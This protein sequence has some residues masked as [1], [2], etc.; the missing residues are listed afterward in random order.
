MALILSFATVSLTVYF[1]CLQ[2]AW[3]QDKFVSH[4]DAFVSNLPTGEETRVKSNSFKWNNST[5]V[6]VYCAFIGFACLPVALVDW[7]HLQLSPLAYLCMVSIATAAWMG[8][9]SS[10]LLHLAWCTG[11]WR[12]KEF[13][14]TL[15]DNPKDW[16]AKLASFRKLEAFMRKFYACI[17]PPTTCAILCVSLMVLAGAAMVRGGTDSLRREK[18]HVY[19]HVSVVAVGLFTGIFALCGIQDIF[20]SM[21]RVTQMCAGKGTYAEPPTILSTVYGL[22]G[23]E[24]VAPVDKLDLDTFIFYVERSHIGATLFGVTVDM[25]LIFKFTALVTPFMWLVSELVDLFQKVQ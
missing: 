13:L 16:R 14:T 22:L 6:T 12:A 1:H 8:W 19:M 11:E 4:L 2:C 15:K 25:R 20:Y 23:T 5:L 9:V 3:S 18:K 21:A 24:A 10:S 7:A 17:A